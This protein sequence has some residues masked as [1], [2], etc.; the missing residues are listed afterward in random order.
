MPPLR[1]QHQVYVLS[2]SSGANHIMTK[3]TPPPVLFVPQ[4]ASGAPIS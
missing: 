1:S 4:E 2:T 3:L